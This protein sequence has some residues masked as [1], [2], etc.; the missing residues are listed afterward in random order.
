MVFF[1]NETR[2]AE[3]LISQ[4]TTTKMIGKEIQAFSLDTVNSNFSKA[5][6]SVF[7]S[8]TSALFKL[9]YSGNFWHEF[10]DQIPGSNVVT[11]LPRLNIAQVS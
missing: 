10:I 1:A 6:C 7:I 8:E 9:Q 5:D 3:R 2:P 11:F 4:M